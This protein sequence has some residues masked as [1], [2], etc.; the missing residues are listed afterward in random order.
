MLYLLAWACSQTLPTKSETQLRLEGI[1]QKRVEECKESEEQNKLDKFR[2]G[3]SMC[4]RV[5]F[6]S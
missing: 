1:E 4:P 6:V 2:G 3:S 5:Y